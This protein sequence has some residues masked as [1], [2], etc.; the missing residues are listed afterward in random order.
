M[1]KKD[2]FKCRQRTVTKV[3]GAWRGGNIKQEKP[4]RTHMAVKSPAQTMRTYF[5]TKTCLQVFLRPW[6]VS[7][8]LKNDLVVTS[9]DHNPSAVKNHWEERNCLEVEE[10]KKDRNDTCSHYSETAELQKE[11]PGHSQITNHWLSNRK[12]A[13]RIPN[14]DN[15]SFWNKDI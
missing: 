9:W 1:K 5:H 3:S 7:T 8:K 12:S 4:L 15:P 11:K 6:V 2:H 13:M 10:G 14:P